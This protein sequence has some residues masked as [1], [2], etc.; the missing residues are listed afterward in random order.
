MLT[1]LNKELADV[2]H[3]IQ[4]G[5]EAERRGMKSEELT[6]FR[7]EAITVRANLKQTIA[8]IERASPAEVVMALGA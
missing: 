5:D 6:R 3:F 7:A 4:Q 1:R 8:T 2:E